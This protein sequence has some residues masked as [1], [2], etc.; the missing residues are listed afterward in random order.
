MAWML[1]A[2]LSPRAAW[3][4]QGKGLPCKGMTAVKAELPQTHDI[5]LAVALQLLVRCLCC[6]ARPGGISPAA[7]PLSQAAVPH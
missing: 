4:L 5:T 2:W 3:N 6:A 1:R 7:A